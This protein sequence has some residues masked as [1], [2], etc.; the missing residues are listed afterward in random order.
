VSF[1][2]QQLSVPNGYRNLSNDRIYYYVGRSG[3]TLNVLLCFFTAKPADVFLEWVGISD[4]EKGLVNGDIQIVKNPAQYPP[5]LS[6]LE[7]A[8][9]SDDEND[10][11]KNEY[12]KHLKDAKEHYEKI[13]ELVKNAKDICGSKSPFSVIDRYARRHKPSINQDSARKWFFAY[14]VFGRR[15][16]ALLPA[17]INSG[18]KNNEDAEIDEAEEENQL[19][20]GRTSKKG[21][22][23]GFRLPKRAKIK[24]I[25]A[26]KKY[27]KV[28]RFMTKIYRMAL[29]KDFGCKTRTVGKV[30][31]FYHPNGDI[32][33]SYWA[34]RGV[35]VKKF[36]LETIQKERYGETRYRTKNAA[37]KGEYT[38]DVSHLYEK[39]EGDAYTVDEVPVGPVNG[40]PM[41]PL[42]V[43]RIRDVLPGYHTGI[44]FSIGAERRLAYQMALF[45]MAIPKTE[46]CALFGIDI[47]EDQWPGIG[48]PEW[49]SLDRGPGSTGD[50]IQEFE[51]QIPVIQ[52]SPSYEGQS[53]AVVESSHPKNMK[54][55]GQPTYVLS[56]LTYIQLMKREILR[57]IADNDMH[58]VSRRVEPHMAKV[59]P[60]PINLF[61]Y[62]DDRLRSDAI[63]L[64]KETAITNLL[65][66]FTVKVHENGV[67]IEGERY[68]SEELRETGAFDKVIISGRYELPAY[69]LGVVNRFMWVKYKNRLFKVE[70]MLPVRSDDSEKYISITMLKELNKLRK[71]NTGKLPSHR[72][73]VQAEAEEWFEQLTGKKW[74]AGSRRKGRAKRRTKEAVAEFS[75]VLGATRG[76]SS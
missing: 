66:K 28:G 48:I 42:Y 68:Y 61:R 55:E 75:Y 65:Q 17:Y 23:Y 2:G 34:F 32:F 6:R 72:L 16:T 19:K 1:V 47:N 7:G 60:T 35:L 64:D 74:D 41:P 12:A 26:Y 58:N 56:N 24:V 76:H 50:L 69:S 36:G 29:N 40:Q 15:L 3:S 43:V 13:E 49:L 38:Q 14:I 57:T 20:L 37:S 10:E 30:K 39:L 52:L 22:G 45:S 9:I 54:A 53:K 73:A 31:E 8:V 21:K 63:P 71:L 46:F 67:Y 5:W 18:Y 70:V 51:E 44:G 4:F 27:R 25:E 11:D 59:F 33:P 62:Y